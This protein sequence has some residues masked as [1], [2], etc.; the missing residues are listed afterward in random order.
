MRARFIARCLLIGGWLVIISWLMWHDLAPSGQ[1]VVATDL[2]HYQ[3]FISKPY[4]EGRLSEPTPA[5]VGW[6]QQVIGE[7]L[8]VEVR[9][10]RRMNEARLRLWYKTDKLDN[11]KVGLQV[12]NAP[13][14]YDLKTI[15]Q[16]EE[17][18]D[19]GWNIG[20]VIFSL[21]RAA[22]T[23]RKAR[24]VIS[25]PGIGAPDTSFVL[26]RFEVDLTGQPLALPDLPL[27]LWQRWNKLL[28][29]GA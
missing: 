18:S 24:F 9:L 19:D 4:P 7:P 26:H 25:A 3:P 27:L 21:D 13:W 17:V 10:P 5:A 8:Y 12:G 11:L 20:E 28:S 15:S 2:I 1:R 22:I 16:V 14:Q 29:Y 23:E 6:Q